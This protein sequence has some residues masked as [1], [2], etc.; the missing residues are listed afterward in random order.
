MAIKDIATRKMLEDPVFAAQCANAL[1][2][3]GKEVIKPEDVHDISEHADFMRILEGEKTVSV[4][5]ARVADVVKLIKRK[6]G[7]AIFDMLSIESQSEL[8][9]KFLARHHAYI[10]FLLLRYA[11]RMKSSEKLPKVY[12]VVMTPERKLHTSPRFFYEYY[13]TE[14]DSSEVV[15]YDRVHMPYDFTVEV[16]SPAMSIEEIN[17]YQPLLRTYLAMQK[18]QDDN[19]R[20]IPWLENHGAERLNERFLMAVSSVTKKDFGNILYNEEGEVEMKH[21]FQGLIDE[22]ME[23]GIEKGVKEGMAKGVK[24]GISKG[25]ADERF[26]A[27]SAMK[28]E[29]F[30]FDMAKRIYSTLTQSEWDAISVCSKE[31][32]YNKCSD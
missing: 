10:S 12:G 20:L 30:S 6:D 2:H 17:R 18:Y 14:N 7:D 29:K 8:D 1:L 15:A 32:E 27:V 16:L 11:E 9:H 28:N 21:M 23:K 3:G 26:R 24:E 31:P 4:S 25:A 19:S 13:D 22:T 5:S